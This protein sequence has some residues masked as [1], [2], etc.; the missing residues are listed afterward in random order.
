MER[1]TQSTAIRGHLRIGSTA[2][3]DLLA[4]R[5]PDLAVGTEK[6]S[7]SLVQVIATDTGQTLRKWR[8]FGR[9]DRSGVSLGV[10][11]INND[12]FDDVVAVRQSLPSSLTRNRASTVKVLLGSASPKE[13]S[14]QTLRFKAFGGEINGPL[15][16]AV[17]DLD[18]DG[19]AEILLS[20]TNKD[21]ERRSLALEAWSLR[22][23]G[24]ER[25]SI[26]SPALKALDPT[27]GY[28]ISLGDLEGD[29]VVELVLGDLQGPNVFVGSF[30]ADGTL[31]GESIIQ[32]YGPDHRAGVS[33]TVISARQTLVH[34]P[35][36]LAKDA[37]PWSLSPTRGSQESLL[38]GL[39][40]PGSLIVQSGDNSEPQPLQV[41]LT[42]SASA[43][44]QRRA[45]ALVPIPWKGSGRPVF[46]SG[47]ISYPP[48]S[49]DHPHLQ[50]ISG[51]PRPVLVSTS[52]GASTLDLLEG[53]EQAGSE[54]TTGRWQSV[55]N[56]ANTIS[57]N[58]K[59]TQAGWVNQ[60][61]ATTGTTQSAYKTRY[62]YSQVTSPLVNYTP[63]FQIDLNPLKLNNPEQ[64][65]SDLAGHLQAYLPMVVKP[66]NADNL[67]Q[68]GTPPPW[69]P[70][71]PNS[72]LPPYGP[73]PNTRKPG[74]PDFQPTFKPARDPGGAS[75]TANLVEQ[76]QQRLIST[77]I[78]SLGINYQHQ[79]SPLWFS[80]E[81][82][83]RE[84]TP[85]P[86][87]TFAPTVEGRKTQGLD[88]SN[89]SSWN[90]NNAFGFWLNSGI[91]EQAQETEVNVD[92]LTGAKTSLK[93]QVVATAEDIYSKRTKPGK[94]ISYLNELLR[95][96]D[97]IFLSADP[98]INNPASA[99]PANAVHVIT[100][101]NNN[102][103]DEHLKFVSL[104]E[105]VKPTKSTTKKPAFIIDS[106]GSESS[107][108]LNQAYPN[109]VQ[110]RQFD[111][112]AW[113]VT[114]ILTIHRWL[115]PE[116]VETIAA[117]LI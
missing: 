17:R 99:N 2:I 111:E 12:G 58:V 116:N 16:I 19:R 20:A 97:L 66:W 30:N 113:Y 100:W 22:A 35:I 89:F 77:A 31:S 43:P 103:D 18:L 26:S 24:F 83:T 34:R 88:C 81:S 80:P 44:R 86:Q 52:A 94:V 110:I 47:G 68:G 8:P 37:L 108:Y 104:P 106:T 9:S 46:S 93:A 98:V 59:Q 28:G 92:W 39:G 60:W 48:V 67:S 33:P 51:S 91:A 42:S 32:P 87:L 70:G 49:A 101:V 40:T 65:L 15:A 75:A 5:I 38:G 14:S 10:G 107:N 7:Q 114:N 105:G 25:S 1:D 63:P 76:F 3:T 117:G 74:L 112:Q 56:S 29:G 69:G 78:A 21:N 23:S 11:D 53:P 64:L 71:A 96:G 115:T 102:S 13:Q 50:P 54:E 6:G 79:H 62:F 109:G 73:A 95:P 27:H 4:D 90:Y 84:L 41:K 36:G 61:G 55:A 57:R 72:V 82:W 45:S 85:T